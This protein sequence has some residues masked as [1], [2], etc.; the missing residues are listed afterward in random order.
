LKKKIEK[1]IY[2]LVKKMNEKECNKKENNAEL[3]KLVS[4]L[5]IH[6]FETFETFFF[7]KNKMNE[8]NTI[9]SDE[10]N[11]KECN[12]KECN[13]KE[14]NEE[15][16]NTLSPAEKQKRNEIII[17]HFNQLT[18][19]EKEEND[20]TCKLVIEYMGDDIYVPLINDQDEY[21]EGHEWASSE[22]DGFCPGWDGYSR[23]CKCENRRVNWEYDSYEDRVY[24]QAY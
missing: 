11:E 23:R 5:T 8:N 22:T 16:N 17:E 13:E 9:S 6:M 3:C 19:I 21:C 7:T 4:D 18:A 24:P 10:C 2:F 15:E 1:K 20:I 12:E 14:C